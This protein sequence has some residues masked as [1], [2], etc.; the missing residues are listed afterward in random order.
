MTNFRSRTDSVWDRTSRAVVVQPSAPMT[1]MMFTRL[2]PA[3]AM[4]TIC[5]ARSGMTRK[6]S[7]KRMRPAPISPP[8]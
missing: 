7:V 4:I 3:M 5:S 8:R 1:R 6:K 2:G